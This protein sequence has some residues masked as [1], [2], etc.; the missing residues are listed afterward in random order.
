MDT[1]ALRQKILDLAIHGKLVPQD[2]NDEPASVLLERIKAEKERLIKEGKIKRSKKSAKTSDT[3]HYQNV[4]FEVP[5]SWVWCKLEDYV[6]SVTDG[7]HQA[8]PKSDIGIPFLVISDVAKGK[9]NFLNTRFVPQE[10][11][12]K[13][14]FDRKPEKGD[15][16]FTVTG[17]YGIVVPVNIDCKFCFQ[18]HIGLIKTLNTSEYLLHLLKSS[19]F[20]GQCDEFAT[21]TAQKTVGLE[22]LRSFLLPIPPFA[23][24]QRIVIE[25]EKWFSLIELIE[26]GKDDLQ[27]TIKQAKSKILDLAI[28]G[29]LVPQDPNEEPAIKLLKRINPDFTPCDNGHY[30][31][32]PDGWTF[33]RLDQIIGYEQSTAYIV[34]STAYDDSYSTPVLTAG[35]SFIIGYTNEAT[36]IYSNLPCIIFDD[37]TTDSKL[38]DFPF[39][40]KSSAMKILKVHKDIEVDYVA[41]FMSITKLVGDTHKRYWISEY[42]KLEIPI[43]SK[44]EQK[45]IIHAIHGIFTQLDLIMESL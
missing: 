25:I 26:G 12:E 24:Q 9:L 4:P 16:L 37:F 36:G 6:K 20:K 45:R 3:P 30:T 19:Y 8:P 18:R 22:T 28:H 42:S 23:E 43:P 7:D 44:A 14:S 15:L 17:S 10:Y 38:V 31:Q 41:M 11:Y 35:K 2:P 27:T 40:V 1:K 39:K 32:L 34:E 29:K 5:S 33:C 21:G 13:I